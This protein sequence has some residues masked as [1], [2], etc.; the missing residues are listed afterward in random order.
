MSTEHLLVSSAHVHKQSPLQPG[1][2]SSD[3]QLSERNGHKIHASSPR[4]TA[5]MKTAPKPDVGLFSEI[6]LS[7]IVPLALPIATATSLDTSELAKINKL[8]TICHPKGISKDEFNDSQRT[9]KNR[10]ATSESAINTAVSTGYNPLGTSEP[11]INTKMTHIDLQHPK[12]DN[13]VDKPCMVGM[14]LLLGVAESGRAASLS[15]L[16]HQ[17]GDVYGRDKSRCVSSEIL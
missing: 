1:Q 8:G 10:E 14:T 2:V 5:K 16:S 12:I 3:Q 17:Q 11:F 7:V 13:V 4:L 15:R 6:P 9:K